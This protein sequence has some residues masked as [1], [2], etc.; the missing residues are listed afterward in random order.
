MIAR[1]GTGP[2]TGVHLT[3]LR[4][5]G[6]SKAGLPDQEDKIMIGPSLGQPIVVHD[7]PD[8]S[9]VITAEGIEDAASLAIATGW[10]SYAAGSVSRLPAVV[11]TISAF[12]Q[13]YLAFDQDVGREAAKAG[14]RALDGALQTRPD[15]IV[16]KFG[17]GK[18]ANKIMQRYGRE[19]VLAFIEFCEA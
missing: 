14:R 19:A 8:S 1:F 13:A 9:S 3:K 17:R 15:L 12:D 5:D 18:D 11:A 2:V 6:S 16:V 4:P 7:N 10:C